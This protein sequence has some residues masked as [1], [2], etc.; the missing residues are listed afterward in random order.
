MPHVRTQTQTQTQTHNISVKGLTV[1]L[2]DPEGLERQLRNSEEW[3]KMS[4]DQRAMTLSAL[5]EVFTGIKKGTKNATST[6][7]FFSH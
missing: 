7:F 5:M 1:N 4:A 3:G 2:Q 6:S